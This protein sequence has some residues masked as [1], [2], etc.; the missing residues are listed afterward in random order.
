MSTS[1]TSMHAG[2]GAQPLTRGP[3]L[4]VAIAW[5]AVVT[6]LWGTFTDMWRVWGA[7]GTFVHGYAIFP[8]ALFLLWQRRERWLDLPL[9]PN[10]SG[11]LLVAAAAAVWLSGALLHLNV[12]M[13]FAAVAVLVACVIGIAG[14]AVFRA[15]A[16][17]L[18][19]MFFA[20]PAGEALVPWLMD[21]TARFTVGALQAVGIP[22]YAEGRLFSIPTGNF[23]VEKACSGIR[24]LIASIV[25]GTLFA[26]L[27][28]RTLWR[29]LLFVAL[30]VVVPV[31]A[32][33]LRAFLIVIL[34]H[35]SNNEI[36][37]GIDHLIY[38][39]IFFG[40][41]MLVVFWIGRHFAEPAASAPSEPAPAPASDVSI[42]TAR[43][44]GGLV[45]AASWIALCALLVPVV[46][47]RITAATLERRIAAEST[48]SESQARVPAPLPGW[49]GPITLSPDWRPLFVAPTRTVTVAYLHGV[50]PVDVALVSYERE[51]A[52][53]ELVNSENRLFDS[54]RWHWLGEREIQVTLPDG[55]SIPVLE[56]MV[57]E[58]LTHRVIWRTFVVGHRAIRGGMEAKLAR[59][60]A[61]LR[62]ASGASTA[63]IV[64]AAQSGER[65]APQREVREFLL[66]YYA[67]LL[68]CHGTDVPSSTT[69]VTA[70]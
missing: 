10:L 39:W 5:L 60:R 70:L 30:C 1:A 2:L 32:N 20:V 4:P 21:F 63:L 67:R 57:R 66:G 23:S 52:G 55:R 26:Q 35:L 16:F 56:T 64:S 58:G 41:V 37:V 6:L 51:R 34:A 36:A 69:C 38:G 43:P 17:P 62:G 7:S 11:V 25:L 40:V 29:R 31:L 47:G 15:A 54:E 18:L 65:A 22:V 53:S 3:R 28:Y 12:V 27:Y 19:F 59:A 68:E 8:I 49:T 14:V 46:A 24:Y 42:P 45:R 33:G 9:E 61:L 13:Q 50:Q 48:L 44:A